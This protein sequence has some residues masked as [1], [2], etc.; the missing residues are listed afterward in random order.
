LPTAQ[1]VLV[2]ANRYQRGV[3]L[4][5]DSALVTTLLSIPAIMLIALLLA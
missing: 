5:R 3:V 1:N 4:A 2:Y